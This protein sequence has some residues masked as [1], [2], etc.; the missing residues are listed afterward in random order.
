LSPT[1]SVGTSSCSVTFH[2]GPGK[3]NTI[4]LGATYS[5]DTHHFGSSGST[6]ITASS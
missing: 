6:T 3:P 2:S 5:G 1:S 4:T